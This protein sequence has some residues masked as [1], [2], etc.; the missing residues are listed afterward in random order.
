[1][2]MFSAKLYRP[3]NRSHGQTVARFHGGSPA[4]CLVISEGADLSDGLLPPP[5]R[6]QS[7]QPAH[8]Y[9]LT[10]NM[11]LAS[12]TDCCRNWLIFGA[13]LLVLRLIPVARLCVPGLLAHVSLSESLTV[14]Y[15][16]PSLQQYSEC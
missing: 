7:C 2:V 4:V 16:L 15:K 9:P 11:V 8:L 14:H 1:M 3:S 12:K 6:L 10:A 13:G 5:T